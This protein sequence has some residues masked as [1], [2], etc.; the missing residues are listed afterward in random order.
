MNACLVPILLRTSSN[1]RKHSGGD[2][3]LMQSA[4]KSHQLGIAILN[5]VDGVLMFGFGI[6]F[7]MQDAVLQPL[8][9][10]LESAF[11]LL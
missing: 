11:G 4:I 1:H 2:K 6:G 9:D 3:K 8:H 5:I 7:I 10:T